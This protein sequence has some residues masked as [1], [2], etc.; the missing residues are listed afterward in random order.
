[1]LSLVIVI[2]VD[3]FALAALDAFAFLSAAALDCLSS[4]SHETTTSGREIRCSPAPGGAPCVSQCLAPGACG[5]I[6]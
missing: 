3:V 5:I 6:T 2:D 1:M 4:R